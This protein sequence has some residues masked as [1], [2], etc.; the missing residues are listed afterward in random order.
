MSRNLTNTQLN[1]ISDRIMSELRKKK[2]TEQVHKNTCD[3]LAE[4]INLKELIKKAKRYEEIQNK[5]S[6]LSKE[7]SLLNVEIRHIFGQ[8][9]Y[10]SISLDNLLKQYDKKVEEELDKLLP[11]KHQIESDIVL[12]SMSGSKDLINEILKRYE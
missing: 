6:E 1:I 3:K 2:I 4:N 9:V 12:A 8:N 11:T 7:S 10:F 5:I